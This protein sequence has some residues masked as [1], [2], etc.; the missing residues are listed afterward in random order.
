MAKETTKGGAKGA[1]VKPT[2]GKGGSKGG[3]K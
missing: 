3:S 2:S 1:P